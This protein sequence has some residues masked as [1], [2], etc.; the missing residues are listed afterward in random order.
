MSEERVQAQLAAE[1]AAQ[2]LYHAAEQYAA[3]AAEITRGGAS[4]ALLRARQAS[5]CQA[6]RE[7]AAAAAALE[8]AAEGS[9]REPERSSGG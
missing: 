6:A 8:A 3:V 5:L 2:Q 4:Q 7:Y 1:I 9:G